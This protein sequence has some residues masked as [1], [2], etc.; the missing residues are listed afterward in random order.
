[1]S[2]AIIRL[3]VTAI[4]L[5]NSILTAKGINPIPFDES[6]FTEIATHVAALAACIWAWWKNNNVSKQAQ[7]AQIFLDGLKKHETDIEKITDLLNGL[8]NGDGSKAEKEG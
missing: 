6:A 4:L 1:M 8:T 5:I 7:E 3:I 2:K